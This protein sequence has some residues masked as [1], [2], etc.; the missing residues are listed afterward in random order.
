MHQSDFSGYARTNLFQVKDMAD[1]R[2]SLDSLQL[3][4]SHLDHSS[5]AGFIWTGDGIPFEGVD[6]SKMAARI[7]PHILEPVY[8]TV[9]G[10]G[11]G[12]APIM[13][14]TKITLAG[15]IEGFGIAQFIGDEEVNF[16]DAPV[17]WS[18]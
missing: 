7:I 6:L 17:L 8:I 1:F 13:G 2:A 18:T 12:E 3:P 15:D 4:I 11:R 14:C 9:A 16:N 10:A 5:L